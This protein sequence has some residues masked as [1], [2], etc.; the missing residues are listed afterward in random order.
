MCPSGGRYLAAHYF[1]G[2]IQLAESNAATL[3]GLAVSF[4]TLSSTFNSCN[5]SYTANVANSVSTGFTVTPTKSQSNATTVQYLGATGTTPF[6]GNLSV[7][8]NV[9]RTVVTSQDGGATSTYTVTVTRDAGVTSDASLSGLVL[10]AGTLS[11]TFTTGNSNY[12]ASVANSVS[13]GFAITAT[14]SQSSSTTVQYL[15]ESGTT[16]FTGALN[17]GA[18]VIRTVVTAQD[19]TTQQSYKVTVT[20]AASADATLSDLTISAGTLTPTFASGTTSYT[21]S[22]ANTVSTGYTVTATKSQ[23]A[24][25]SADNAHPRW[26]IRC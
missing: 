17:V 3:S 6:T 9:I 20:R 18:N 10:S 21:A 16:P 13:T 5:T 14:K 25:T 12:T 1:G 11:P 15:G 26:A 8:A 4:G 24:A 22:V 7:G 19:G 2:R 23:S